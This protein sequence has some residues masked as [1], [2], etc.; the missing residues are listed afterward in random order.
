MQ[1][2]NLKSPINQLIHLYVKSFEGLSSDVWWLSIMALINRTG[3]VVVFFLTLY[4]TEQLHFSIMQAGFVMSCH[5][6]GSVAGAYLGG[7][8]SDKF[9]YYK[10][11]FW[12]LFLVGFIFLGLV[13]IKTYVWFCILIFLAATVGDSFRPAAQVAIGAYSTS[14]NHTRSLSLYR[15][16]INLGFALGAGG[17]GFIADSFGYSWLFIIDAGTCIMAAL[18]LL[19]KLKEKKP[20]LSEEEQ[21]EKDTDRPIYKDYWYLLFIGCLLLSTI[22]FM[23]L[24]TTYPLF[25]TEE[26]MYSKKEYGG[27]MAFNGFLIFLIE[28]PLVY[29]FVKLKKEMS[30]IIW[31]VFLIGLSY[32]CFN[33]LGFTPWVAIVSVFLIS[34]GE[35]INFPFS[36]TLALQRSTP[37]NQGQYMALYSMMFSVAFIIAPI[38]GTYLIDNYGYA[39]LWNVMSLLCGISAVGLLI[40]NKKRTTMV[41]KFELRQTANG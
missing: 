20:K 5:G 21:K 30:L 32:L 39:V 15:M 1:E 38:S 26:L 7:I 19:W 34:I 4:L 36:N 24:L 6:F 28:M 35:I 37:N 22:A 14:E 13:F 40:L 18:F 17:A 41:E 27:L 29:F 3:T 16:A 9:G 23:Q 2:S 25:C 31:G 12:S 10:V 11:M 8:L 33:I